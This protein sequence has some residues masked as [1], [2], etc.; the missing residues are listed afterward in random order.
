[1]MYVAP[2]ERRLIIPI[3]AIL[4]L[5]GVEKSRIGLLFGRVSTRSAIPV[6]MFIV[7][8]ELRSSHR[9]RPTCLATSSMGP[10]GESSLY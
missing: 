2:A 8:E 6:R 10:P 9:V 4:I 5:F 3:V 7:S 1:M